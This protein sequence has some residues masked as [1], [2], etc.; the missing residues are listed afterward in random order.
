[1]IVETQY[2]KATALNA[3]CTMMSVKMMCIKR[4]R[5]GEREEQLDE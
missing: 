4:G 3:N 5:E 2:P 1:M